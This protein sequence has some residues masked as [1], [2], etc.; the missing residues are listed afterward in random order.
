MILDRSVSV[1]MLTIKDG[2]KLIFKDLGGDGREAIVLRALAIKVASDGE[3]WIGSRSCR[4]QGK[5]DIVLYGNL[6]DMEEHHQVGTKYLWLA[7]GG[8][9][10]LHGREK[11]SWTHL[12]EH[13]FK[14]N[15]PAEQLRFHQWR[16]SPIPLGNRL[17]RLRSD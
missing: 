10:E 16:N 5:A 6:E 13:I 1:R 9:V 4:Y 8:T 11:T 17:S 2:G 12:S 3:L 14:D 7:S 15:V